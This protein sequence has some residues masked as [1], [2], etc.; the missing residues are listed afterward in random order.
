MDLKEVVSVMVLVDN[1]RWLL[2]THAMKLSLIGE[3]KVT[4]QTVEEKISELKKRRWNG[5][6]IKA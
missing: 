5:V 3:D 1:A 4:D 2:K 6:T